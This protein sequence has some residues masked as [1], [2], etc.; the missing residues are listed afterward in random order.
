ML[1]RLGIEPPFRW[2][3]ILE[4]GCKSKIPRTGA[5]SRRAEAR[6]EEA[7]VPS[8]WCYSSSVS[9]TAQCSS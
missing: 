6:D 9:S 2:S 8:P 7:V 4:S 1:F 3:G 5:V